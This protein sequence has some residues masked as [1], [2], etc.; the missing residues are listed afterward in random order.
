VQHLLGRAATPDEVSARTRDIAMG[1]SE[2][3]VTA[4]VAGSE[5]YA[6]WTST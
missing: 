6:V 5:E 4:Q 1:H 2:V 3:W